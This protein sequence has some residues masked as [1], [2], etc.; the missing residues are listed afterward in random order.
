M[1]ICPLEVLGLPGCNASEAELLREQILDAVE[2]PITLG[3]VTAI[4]GYCLR[5]DLDPA[6]PPLSWPTPKVR[7]SVG[8]GSAAS[9]TVGEF[10]E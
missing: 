4:G 7:G 3:E 9:A 5:F 8:S 1:G 2:L 10:G 6:I